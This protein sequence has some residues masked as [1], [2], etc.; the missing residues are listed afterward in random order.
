MS[1]NLTFGDPYDKLFSEFAKIPTYLINNT[2]MYN[3]NNNALYNMLR[4]P[5]HLLGF[6]VGNI[7]HERLDKFNNCIRYNSS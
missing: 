1:L 2:N 4:Y 3:I 7:M 5:E 6:L